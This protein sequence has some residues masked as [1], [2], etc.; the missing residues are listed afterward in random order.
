MG[1]LDINNNPNTIYNAMPNR[2]LA[3]AYNEVLNAQQVLNNPNLGG[4]YF[5]PKQNLMDIHK[6]ASAKNTPSWA[7][8][9]SNA[10]PSIGEIVA[11]GATKGAFNQG[12]VA[13]GLDKQ[14]QRQ[15]AYNQWLKENEQQQAKDFVQMAKEQLGMDIAEDDRKFNREQTAL[16]RAY[17]KARDEWEQSFKKEGFE[18][19]KDK[20]DRTYNL[21]VDKFN[22][23]KDKFDKTFNYT[24]ERKQ[25]EEEEKKKEEK[26]KIAL[27]LINKLESK[28][29]GED[30]IKLYKIAQDNDNAEQVIELLSANENFT[31]PK[32]MADV[33]A[34]HF[35][36][37][38]TG[39]KNK[40]KIG[41]LNNKNIKNL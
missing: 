3:N 22:W 38:T 6:Q 35:G 39:D 29:T 32:T 5:A 20:F 13:E 34:E 11:L 30:Y 14:K 10:M 15:M 40:Y 17:K 4:A 21:D 41:V 23:D 18:F 12:R 24:Q 33:L 36:L 28:M 26:K 8:A 7:I 31:D 2:N 25:A 16:D 19:D 37:K 9:L 1:I 27:D